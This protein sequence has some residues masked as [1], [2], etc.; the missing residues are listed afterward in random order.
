MRMVVGQD[1]SEES[2]CALDL[3]G[4]DEK[5]FPDRIMVAVG[6]VQKG[7]KENSR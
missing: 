5:I 3:E 2:Q 6:K 1:F 4:Q 7:G